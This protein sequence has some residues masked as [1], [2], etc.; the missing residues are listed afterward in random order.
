MVLCY[1]ICKHS[2]VKCYVFISNNIV[3]I[4]TYTPES[5]TGPWD[6][7]E[8]RFKILFYSLLDGPGQT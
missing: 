4:T 2:N 3:F 5:N 6:K 8:K 7:N 1:I